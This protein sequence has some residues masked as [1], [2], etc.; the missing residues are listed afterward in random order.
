MTDND[1]HLP[2]D[3]PRAAGRACVLDNLLEVGEIVPE[4]E[5]LVELLLVLHHKDA[6]AAVLQDVAAGLRAVGG[7][8]AGG[9]PAGEDGGHVGEDPLGRVEAEDADGG[10]ARHAELDEGLGH[11]PRLGVVIRPGPYQLQQQ[12]SRHVAVVNIYDCHL[13][14]NEIIFVFNTC[15]DV[16]IN[17]VIIY[18]CLRET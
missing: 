10:V 11:G 6:A 16:D 7:V 1:I 8:D 9:E 15:R 17:K 14:S 2:A 4:G 12:W 18:E 5:D 3:D 13:I